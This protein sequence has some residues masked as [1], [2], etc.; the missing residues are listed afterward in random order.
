MD[1]QLDPVITKGT[2]T[3]FPSRTVLEV[4]KPSP[5]QS[6]APPE[7]AK[8]DWTLESRVKTFSVEPKE[9]ATAPPRFAAKLFDKL[10]FMM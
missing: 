8:L 2:E 9:V 1:C 6:I 4:L 7:R 5:P 10:E 3:S